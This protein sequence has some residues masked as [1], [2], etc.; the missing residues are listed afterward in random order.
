M[1]GWPGP[2]PWDGTGEPWL[3]VGVCESGASQ[4]ALRWALLEAQRRDARLL[5]V[6]VWTGGTVE[7]QRVREAWLLS[8][9]RHAV[10]VTGVR[11]RTWLQLVVGEPSTVLWA[12]A[13]EADLLVLGDHAAAGRI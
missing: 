5:V 8:V 11:G 9:V 4:A 2:L 13:E 1:T 7:E 6:S 10:A 12:L 3:A